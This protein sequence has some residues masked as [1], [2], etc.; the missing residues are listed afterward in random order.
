[1]EINI[2]NRMGGGTQDFGILMDLFAQ[3]QDAVRSDP[4]RAKKLE[5]F[6]RTLSYLIP[7]SFSENH[8]FLPPLNGAPSCV[9]GAL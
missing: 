2:E 8:T 6:A 7:V 3:Y 5:D 1:M 4:V 9:R